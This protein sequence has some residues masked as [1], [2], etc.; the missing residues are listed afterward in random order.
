MNTVVINGL[1]ALR[2][3]G[4][5][6]L[7][8]LLTDLHSVD[9]LDKVVILANEKNRELFAELEQEKL[10][11]IT[12]SLASVNIFFRVVWET[13][14]LPRLLKRLAASRYYA[15]GGIMLTL[16][17]VGCKSYTALRNMLP[18]D[19]KER[20]RFPL[21]S[22]S[23][24]KLWLLK[25]VYL[26]S[27]RLADGVVF[28]SNY[29]KSVVES[30]YPAVKCKS[31]TIYHGLNDDFMAG[32][33]TLDESLLGE[34]MKGQYYLYVS[35]LD[36]YKA[37]KEVVHSWIDK[38]QTDYP[39]VLV[40]PA[41]NQ[42]GEDVQAL[43]NEKAQGRVIYLGARGYNELPSLY[44]GARALIFGS[45]CECCP[46]ILLEKLASGRPVICSDIQ[47][48]P[49]FAQGAALLFNPYD[50]SSLAGAV[51][52]LEKSDCIEEYG[53]MALSRAQNFSWVET[54][55]KTFNFICR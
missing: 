44:Q 48:M 7:I 46:N 23:R 4:Q 26:L 36:V 12:P 45:S 31:S 1:S 30:Y 21:L 6:Y 25:Y 27:Y 19:D 16:M 15:P 3:G 24:F 28:I 35:I 2:G 13:F 55:Q 37:Q 42:Y 40:G 53:R 34:L 5:T 8:N 43:I 41:Y 52:K 14:F 39:L 20:Q 9:S 10:L 47:P 49:E 18:F 22:Y 11:V 51:D 54:R 33:D 50:S 32:A 29:S 38:V 17:P